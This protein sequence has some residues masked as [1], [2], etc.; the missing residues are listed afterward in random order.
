MMR[1][2]ALHTYPARVLYVS[3]LSSLLVL[4]LCATV[5]YWLYQQQSQTADILGENLISKRAALNLEGTLTNLIA[6]HKKQATDVSALH[7]EVRSHL[8][9]INA[10]A[11][12]EQ[13][14]AFAAQIDREFSDYLRLYETAQDPQLLANHLQDHALA[15]CREL[16]M[17]NSREEEQSEQQHRRSL[18]RMTWGLAL[19]G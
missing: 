19:V 4:G 10:D 3:A 6:L 2:M 12:K 16:R 1:A 14:R 17:F 18:R 9:D 11:D 5:A 13:E 8:A 7:A 15:T